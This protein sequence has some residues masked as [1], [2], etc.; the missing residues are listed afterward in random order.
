MQEIGRQVK[1]FLSESVDFDRLLV[2]NIWY[3]KSNFEY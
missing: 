1:F 3:K 2:Q